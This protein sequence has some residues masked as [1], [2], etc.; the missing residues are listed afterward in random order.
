[1]HNLSFDLFDEISNG[2]NLSDLSLGRSN[3]YYNHRNEAT[4]TVRVMHILH[5]DR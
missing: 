4:A 2:L 3:N 1:M 5:S